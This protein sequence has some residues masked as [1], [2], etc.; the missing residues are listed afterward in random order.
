[1]A[2][3]LKEAGVDVQFMS[4]DGSKDPSFGE[5]AGAAA[6]GSI[7]SCPCADPN[8]IDA[9]SAF[10]DG[11]RAEF[12]K[13]APGTFAADLF[14]VTNIVV[15]ALSELSGDEDI[16]EVRAHVVD[17]FSNAEALEGITKSYTWEDSGEFQ[18]GPGDIWIYEWSDK[19]GDF[20]SVGPAEE[21]I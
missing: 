2:K 10:V 6:E 19:D 12:G 15:Q 21:L 11:M 4:D 20:V 5:L 16:E 13:N 7:V 14:D 9:A 17:F 8:K 1:L 18:G 3:Q